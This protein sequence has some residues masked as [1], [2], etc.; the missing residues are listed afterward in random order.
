MVIGR[1]EDRSSP[2]GPMRIKPRFTDWARSAETIRASGE[3][4]HQQ[5]GHMTASDLPHHSKFPLPATGRPHMGPLP[6][7]GSA[8]LAGDDNWCERALC[9]DMHRRSRDRIRPGLLILPSFTSA[10]RPRVGGRPA[11]A[12]RCR[13]TGWSHARPSIHRAEVAD[14]G[15]GVERAVGRPPRLAEAGFEEGIGDTEGNRRRR[16]AA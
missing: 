7:H 1:T 14:E 9:R 12:V 13:V 10:R 6:S 5:A 4:P 3:A 8:V 2:R 11:C 16:E 15:L